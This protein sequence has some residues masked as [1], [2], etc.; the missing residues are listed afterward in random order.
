[1]SIGR[2]SVQIA[3]NTVV[4]IKT[5]K[6]SIDQLMNPTPRPHTTRKCLSHR[7]EVLF[8]HLLEMQSLNKLNFLI[9]TIFPQPGPTEIAM[10]KTTIHPPGEKI[11]KAILDNLDGLFSSWPIIVNSQVRPH[12]HRLLR[13]AFWF[14]CDVML[15]KFLNHCR[16]IHPH[17]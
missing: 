14:F 11:K 10:P 9:E 3:L 5:G 17:F 16:V 13:R 7:W 1:M 15:T 4:Q 12:P 2:F 8:S 6:K